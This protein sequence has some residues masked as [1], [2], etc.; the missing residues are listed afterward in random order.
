MT[1]LT[2]DITCRKCNT[3]DGSKHFLNFTNV[4][5]SEW[6]KKT[7]F[8]VGQVI[9]KHRRESNLIC[10]FCGSKNEEISNISLGLDYPFYDF[11][12][13]AKRCQS[14]GEFIFIIEMNKKGS[15]IQTSNFGSNIL[16]GLFKEKGREIIITY[17]NNLDS[18]IFLDLD[19]GYFFISITGKIVDIKNN[20][21]VSRIERL[22]TDG[23]LITDIQNSTN[24]LFDALG[25]S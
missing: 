10:P 12:R 3:T 9:E 22:E 6:L 23:I 24:D 19:E 11:N 8:E 15:Q 2:Y 1:T 13:L 7:E 5:E 17:L 18:N 21:I 20:K 16:P 25:F 4:I 14:R